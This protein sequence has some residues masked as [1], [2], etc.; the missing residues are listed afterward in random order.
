MKKAIL[1]VMVLVM[2]AFVAC[3]SLDEGKEDAEITAY[4]KEEMVEKITGTWVNEEYKNKL[5]LES[6]K[7]LLKAETIERIEQR[8]EEI[9]EVIPEVNSLFLKEEFE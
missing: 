2:F 7:H 3:G 9:F 5:F 6:D 8:L 1:L 4:T